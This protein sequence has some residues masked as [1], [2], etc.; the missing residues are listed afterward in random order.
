[1]NSDLVTGGGTI[2]VLNPPH[3]AV[4][5]TVP[6]ATIGVDDGKYGL[7]HFLRRKPGYLKYT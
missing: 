7:G 1:M 6:V 3:E 4:I 5:G 2:E